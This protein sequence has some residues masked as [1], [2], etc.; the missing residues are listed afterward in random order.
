M[1]KRLG[2]LAAVALTFA[3]AAC[4][5]PTAPAAPQQSHVG[6][7]PMSAAGVLIGSDT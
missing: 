3:L 5:D 1:V 4:T 7:T 2:I 6:A